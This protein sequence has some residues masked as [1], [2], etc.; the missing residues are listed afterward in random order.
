MGSS[1]SSQSCKIDSIGSIDRTITNLVFS[2]PRVSSKTDYISF[3]NSRP[4]CSLSYITSKTG[5][6]ISSIEVTPKINNYPNKLIIYSHGNAEDI[7]TSYDFYEGMSETLGI[8]II[9]YDYSGYGLTEGRPSEEECYDAIDA[10]VS[11]YLD[12]CDGIILIGRSLGTGVTVDY[13]SKQKK[14]TNPIMLISAY[15]SIP[16]VILDIPIESSFRHN[17]FKTIYKV[18]KVRCPV[19]LIHGTDDGLINVKHTNA[20]FRALP[21]KKFD[22]LYVEGTG[23]NDVLLNVEAKTF[24]EVIESF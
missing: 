22:P 6:N 7:C 17:T 1:F 11:N 16:R 3:L 8:R 24:V 23:H 18:D 19:K 12:Q 9:G 14:W 15:K 5:A 4:R 10:V 13:V 2:P 20:I 21:N